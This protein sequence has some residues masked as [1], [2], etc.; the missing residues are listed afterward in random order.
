MTTAA[1]TSSVSPRLEVELRVLGVL[2]LLWMACVVQ[3][4][5]WAWATLGLGGALWELPWLELMVPQIVASGVVAFSLVGDFPWVRWPRPAGSLPHR[6]RWSLVLGS[7]PVLYVIPVL[8]WRDA[9]A[10]ALPSPTPEAVEVAFAQLLQLPRSLGMKF[11]TWASL[12]AVVDAIVLGTHAQWSRDG[13]VA[14]TLLWIT[15]IGPLTAIMIGWTRVVVRPEYLSAPRGQAAFARR[16]DVRVR[17]VVNATIAGSGMIAAPLCV[18][19]LWIA[20]HQG[21]EA[22]EQARLLAER[23]GRLAVED[24][25]AA[26]GHLLADN[27]GATVQVGER[28]FGLKRPASPTAPGPHDIDADGTPDLLVVRRSGTRVTVPIAPPHDGPSPQLALLL[29]GLLIL[30]CTVSSVALIAGDVHRDVVRAAEQAA[31]VA[32]GG[33]PSPMTEG[34]FATYEIRQLVGS[35]DRLVH[36]ITEANVAKYVAI[37]KAKEADRLKSQ[38]LAN[39]SH[40]LRSPLNSILGF[41]ELLLAEI[42]GAL[43][44]EQREMLALV[45]DNGRTLLQ[46]I[47]DILDTAKIEASRLDLHPEPTPLATV[48]NRAIANAKKRQKSRIDYHV[49][50]APGLP[51]AFVDPYRTVQAL[52]NVLL[53]AGERMDSGRIDIS[54][55]LGKTERGRMIFVQIR[56]PIAPATAEQLGRARRGFY[57]IPGHRG[58]GLSLPLA[59]SILELGGGE[60]AIEDLDNGMIFTAG[61]WAPAAR[62]TPPV[63]EVQERA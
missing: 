22:T 25:G 33:S 5:V 60:L 1:P 53:F 16:A 46:Q 24:E 4:A 49:D 40:D 3:G 28:T 61:L 11:L 59:G 34:T 10:R 26:L 57:R 15:L 23:M 30:G 47:D 20:S 63:R 7:L 31:A 32:R 29:G 17:L 2:G 39:M 54:V 41:S 6:V 27:P 56:T 50:V 35:V 42:D 8:W 14:M 51:P 21:L 36:R 37:E 18:G 43:E 52:E 12:A 45:Y 55:R 19:Y 58:L 9:R 44:P 13:I 62:R 48:L 38:F